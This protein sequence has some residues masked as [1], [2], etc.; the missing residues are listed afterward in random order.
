MDYITL[1]E[2]MNKET[3]ELNEEERKEI[4][5]E[6]LY[7]L[8]KEEVLEILVSLPNLLS[9][10]YWPPEG[11]STSIHNVSLWQIC[12]RLEWAIEDSN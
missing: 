5:W 7:D 2:N 1:L 3:K 10:K 9:M 12:K 6:A 8:T 11:E 4:I